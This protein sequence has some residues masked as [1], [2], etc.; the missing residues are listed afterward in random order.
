MATGKSK[1]K[2]T[3]TRRT[4]RILNKGED[5]LHQVSGK[6]LARIGW[7]SGASRGSLRIRKASDE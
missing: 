3:K 6:K 4:R 5:E 2:A 1:N 7:G